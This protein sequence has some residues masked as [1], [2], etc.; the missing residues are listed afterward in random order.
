MTEPKVTV[1]AQVARPLTLTASY[2]QG[3]QSLDAIYITQN[4]QAPF[5]SITAAEGGAIYHQRFIPVDLTARAVGFYTHVSR[6]L[7]FNPL[8]GRLTASTGT[9]RDG[10]LVSLRATGRWFDELASATYAH[11]TYDADGTLV[12]YV[13]SVIARSDTAVFGPLGRRRFFDHGL[14]GTAGFAVNFVGPRALAVQPDRGVDAGA[15]RLGQRALELPAPGPLGPEPHRRALS[16]DRAL[17]RLELQPP[18]GTDA[19]SDRALHRG[20]AVLAAGDAVVPLRR[21]ERAMKLHSRGLALLALGAVACGGTTGG[22]LIQMPLQA[23]GIA[24]DAS[25]PFTFVTGQGWNVTLTEAEVVFGPLYF[26]I[27]APSPAVFRSGVVIV[28]ATK[29]FIVDMLDPTLQN[30]PGGADGETGTAVSVEIGFLH[31]GQP[32]QRH[33][34]GGRRRRSHTAAGAAGRRRSDGDGLPGRGG[35]QAGGG[36]R[37]CRPGADHRRA[38]LAVQ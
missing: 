18:L 28:Q 21:G 10:G 33:G 1:L 13:P 27:D 7:I 37:L 30:V 6:D 14:T 22:N 8:L 31:D 17:L 11:A 9:T 35:D 24:R 25:Q 16:V 20:A 19:G 29:Q 26:N 2:G 32:V 5:S 23:G 34:P 38:R 15:R 3:A 12:P 36:R 4:E